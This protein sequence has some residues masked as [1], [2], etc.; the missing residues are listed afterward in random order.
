MFKT[1]K[2]VAGMTLLVSL[3]VPATGFA[4][5]TPNCGDDKVKTWLISKATE[6]AKEGFH[7]SNA[8]LVLDKYMGVDAKTNYP[9]EKNSSIQLGVPKI[10]NHRPIYPISIYKNIKKISLVLRS[11]YSVLV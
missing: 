6:G 3:N 5:E 8:Q 4:R 11:S 2:I 1:I 7:S 10:R 9:Q